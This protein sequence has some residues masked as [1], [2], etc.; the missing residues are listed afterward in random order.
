MGGSNRCNAP[1]HQYVIHYTLYPSNGRYILYFFLLCVCLASVLLLK[2]N[3]Q[4]WLV[5]ASVL[6][7]VLTGL[8]SSVKI[9]R[10]V[11]GGLLFLCVVIYKKRV[12]RLIKKG[13]IKYLTAFSFSA[14]VIIYLLNPFF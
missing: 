2:C 7:G 13:T 14:L 4:L 5:S 6:C 12:S 8:A 3:Q 11:I 1:S 9:T 10:I